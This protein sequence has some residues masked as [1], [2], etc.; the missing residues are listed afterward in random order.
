MRSMRSRSY[1]RSLRAGCERWSSATTRAVRG[2]SVISEAAT[3]PS[4]RSSHPMR[5]RL[6]RS[7]SRRR[8][9]TA[10]FGRDRRV[11]AGLPKFHGVQ[12]VHDQRG[13]DA[14]RHRL[15]DPAAA[16]TPSWSSGVPGRNQ[17]EP[18][19]RSPSPGMCAKSPTSPSKRV[20]IRATF[21]ARH[22][23]SRA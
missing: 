5:W 19:M 9:M 7:G 23:R 12:A 21:L 4:R 2:R 20:R 1:C 22:V 10:G 14:D 16:A 13:W 6:S 8:L 11:R 3:E 15:F 18:G 17:P